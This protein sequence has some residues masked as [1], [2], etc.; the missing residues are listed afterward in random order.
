MS[1]AKIKINT[2]R[3]ILSH[4]REEAT[5]EEYKFETKKTSKACCYKHRIPGRETSLGKSR[6]TARSVDSREE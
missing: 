1:F 4:L 2:L 5:R 3:D 6:E